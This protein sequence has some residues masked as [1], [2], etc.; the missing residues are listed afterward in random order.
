[1]LARLLIGVVALCQLPFGLAACGGDT[2]ET[3]L[4]VCLTDLD[5]A[6][7]PNIPATF[8]SV[9]INVV[10]PTCGRTGEDTNCHSAR[11]KQGGLDLS[12]PDR[13]YDGLL[14]EHGRARVV[15]E[16]PDCSVLMQRIEAD[17]DTVRMPLGTLRLD[18]GLRC[19]IQQWIAAGAER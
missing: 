7:T 4:P 14:G 3:Q 13:A 12:T 5:E 11:K 16:N 18:P 17:D 19:A 9:Y 1:M 6:C 2:G 15:P 10:L 8:D